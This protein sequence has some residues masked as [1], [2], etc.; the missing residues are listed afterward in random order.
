MKRRRKNTSPSILESIPEHILREILSRLPIR[1]IYTCLRVCATWRS[2]ISDPYFPKLHEQTKPVGF[3]ALTNSKPAPTSDFHLMEFTKSVSVNEIEIINM[4]FRTPFEKMAKKMIVSNTCHGFFSFYEPRSW[5]PS[6]VC[7]PIIN[8]YVP[9]PHTL[10][11]W[12][13]VRRII[14][15]FDP[16]TKTYKLLRF[17]RHKIISSTTVAEVLALNATCRE[18]EDPWR[19]INGGDISASSFCDNSYKLA[20][21]FMNGNYHQVISIGTRAD[22]FFFDS[23]CSFDFSSER[24]KILP[25]PSDFDES[26]GYQTMAKTKTKTT[27]RRLIRTCDMTI[28]TLDDLL[29]IGVVLR[30]EPVF[31]VWAMKEYGVKESWTKYIAI[32]THTYCRPVSLYR[33][34]ERLLTWQEIN[35]L[36]SC[37]KQRKGN[38]SYFV[39]TESI[40]IPKDNL[41]S[42]FGEVPYHPSFVSLKNV[43]G[44]YYKGIKRG[45]RVRIVKRQLQMQSKRA[46]DKLWEGFEGV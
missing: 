2:L 20:G 29:C 8:E 33:D 5:S 19:S 31:Q 25:P 23:I 14:L 41:T 6:Y 12:F 11:D 32:K 39:F 9:V 4:K 1:D 24:F 3:L 38:D 37:V 45:R 21:P 44:H 13:E 36:A 18:T 16:V 10:R 27:R 28:R 22:S 34:G 30:Q 26:D 17:L 43:V 35:V 46:L 42:L 7:N 15:G 40:V